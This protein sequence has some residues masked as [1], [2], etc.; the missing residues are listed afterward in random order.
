M[1]CKKLLNARR[2]H[3]HESIL[4]SPPFSL[5]IAADL[6]RLHVCMRLCMRNLEKCSCLWLLLLLVF[7]GLLN[8]P[9]S[10]LGTRSIFWCIHEYSPWLCVWVNEFFMF[11]SEAKIRFCLF[12]RMTFNSVNYLF[13]MSFLS[14]FLLFL[15]W[16][17][18]TFIEGPGG[19]MSARHKSNIFSCLRFQSK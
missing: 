19:W 14:F 10:A 5:R 15:F 17:F 12:W 2:T 11:E 18:F 4:C 16:H 3:V 1:L 9:K 13:C 8:T 7:A 6:K